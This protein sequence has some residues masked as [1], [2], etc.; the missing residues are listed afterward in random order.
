M[1]L[2]SLQHL[3]DHISFG[4][5]KSPK[6]SPSLKNLADDVR[7]SF[8]SPRSSSSFI[9]MYPAEL[10]TV[11]CTTAATGEFDFDLPVVPDGSAS[12][13]LLVS[14]SRVFH[15]GLLLPCQPGGAAQEHEDGV[16]VVSSVPQCSDSSST[17]FDSAQSMLRSCSSA[18]SDAGR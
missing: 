4:W 17:L 7:H 6:T 11:R 9:D 2:S 18:M 8:E 14:A 15:G 13:T 10:F 3:D 12:S 16:D 5:V 1:E